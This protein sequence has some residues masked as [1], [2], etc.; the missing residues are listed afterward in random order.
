MHITDLPNELLEEIA[1]LVRRICYDSGQYDNVLLNFSMT[2][3]AF[4]RV[5]FRYVYDDLDLAEKT[6]CTSKKVCDLLHLIHKNPERGYAVERLSIGPWD[7]TEYSNHWPPIESF[8]RS[9]EFLKR[10]I[11]TNKLQDEDMGDL[12]H[13]PCGLLVAVLFY[14]LPNLDDI[15]FILTPTARNMPSAT[16]WLVMAMDIAPLPCRQKVKS[17]ELE[18]LESMPGDILP[19]RLTIGALLDLP[20]LEVLRCAE[21]D[22]PDIQSL[23]FVPDN[24]PLARTDSNMQGTELTS[25]LESTQLALSLRDH[26]SPELSEAYTK[27]LSYDPTSLDRIKA[28]QGTSLI[29]EISFYNNPCTIWPI[30][31]ILR[32]PKHLREFDCFIGSKTR[33]NQEHVY[34]IHS[35]LLEHRDTLTDITMSYYKGFENRHAPNFQL[36]FSEFYRLQSLQVSMILLADIELPT[37][38]MG[39]ILP[40]SLEA[41]TLK[42]RYSALVGVSTWDHAVLEVIT[43][44]AA[45][46]DIKLEKLKTVDVRVINHSW[47]PSNSR[48]LAMARI[49]MKERGIEYV[50]PHSCRMLKRHRTYWR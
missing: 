4:Y 26:L 3:R 28:L 34:A 37:I 10:T 12:H 20:N 24:I 11:T 15:F 49:L 19:C 44:I 50:T 17:L 25:Q 41:L 5:A 36:D 43:K 23:A 40:A 45:L 16:K 30:P 32:V 31:D 7:L 48:N 27:F 47:R 33:D 21:N 39:D 29:A 2:C 38:Q 14:L 46:K 9:Y 6:R 22:T 13:Y 8:Q 18:Y 42:I 1:R 35:A